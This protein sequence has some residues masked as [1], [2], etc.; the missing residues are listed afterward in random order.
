MQSAEPGQHMSFMCA[1]LHKQLMATLPVQEG[2]SLNTCFHPIVLVDRWHNVPSPG[3]ALAKNKHIMP[4]HCL[5]EI[6]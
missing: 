5:A 4:R 6:L 3:P 2:L 1:I